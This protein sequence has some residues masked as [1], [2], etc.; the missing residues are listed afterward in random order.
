MNSVER[1]MGPLKCRYLP[2]LT[3]LKELK[4]GKCMDPAGFKREMF[5]NGGQM[6]TQSLLA[7]ANSIKNKAST[8]LQ[9]NKMY[10][11]TLKK[12]GQCESYLTTEVFSW[13]LL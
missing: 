5:I 1:E 10:I 2:T 8:P 3:S 7:M 6:L 4:R 13:S 11:Q 9:W 12:M